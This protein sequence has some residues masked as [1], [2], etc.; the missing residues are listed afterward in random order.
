MGIRLY[1]IGIKI[2]SIRSTKARLWLEGR[3]NWRENLSNKVDP[4]RARI[5]VHASSLGEMEQGLPILRQIRL[6]LPN[7]QIIL[8]FFSPSGYENFKELDLCDILCYLPL[9]LPDEAHDFAEILKPELAIF[10]KYDIWPNLV[11]ALAQGNTKIFLAPAIFRKNQ[12]YFRKYA[13][14]FFKETLNRFT[15]IYVQ[16]Q[17][18]LDLLKDFG[19]P[20]VFLCGDSRFDRAL[21]NI[22]K[23]YPIDLRGIMRGGPCLVA[24]STWPKEEKM[25]HALLKSKEELN[26]ILAPHDVSKKNIIRLRSEF[27]GFNLVALSELSEPQTKPRVILVDGIG[28]LKYLYR[29]ADIALIGGGFGKGVHSTI[30]AAVYKKPIL[31]GPNHRKFI[32]TKELLELGLALEIKNPKQALSSLY[33]KLRKKSQEPS[34]KVNYENY[35]SEKLGAAEVIAQAILRKVESHDGE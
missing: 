6:G 13:G 4:D 15:Q 33:D 29:F 3:R 7:H 31:F 26:L 25:L 2:A 27:D 9:D 22:H 1:L 17:Y 11:E 5:L 14:S 24:G 28:D 12:V 20:A 18:S 32:E 10:I 35:I 16:D 34:F 23:E 30:E 8:S 21:E 19:H